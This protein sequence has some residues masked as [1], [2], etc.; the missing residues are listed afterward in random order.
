MLCHVLAQHDMVGCC[1]IKYN[2]TIQYGLWYDYGHRMICY[3]MVLLCQ[4][5]L[6]DHSDDVVWP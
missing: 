1:V 3:A 5:E 2:E 6:Y 4:K